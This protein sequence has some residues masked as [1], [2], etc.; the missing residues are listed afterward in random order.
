MNGTTAMQ[1]VLV[2]LPREP[3]SWLRPTFLVTRGKIRDFDRDVQLP[4]VYIAVLSVDKAAGTAT[5]EVLG[6][7]ASPSTVG[8]EGLRAMLK[9]RGVRQ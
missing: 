4:P 9:Q 7:N 5:Y 2:N 1:R 6:S 8:I 3:K